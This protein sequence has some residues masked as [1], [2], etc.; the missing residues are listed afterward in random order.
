MKMCPQN[1][2]VIGGQAKYEYTFPQD[3]KTSLNGLNVKCGDIFTGTNTSDIMV[4]D[5]LWGHF[6]DMISVPLNHGVCGAQVRY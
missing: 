3:D 1:T 6:L 5:G 4:F 2:Y